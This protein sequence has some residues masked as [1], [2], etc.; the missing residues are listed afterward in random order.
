MATLRD[1]IDVLLQK[2]GEDET[3]LL[4]RAVELGLDQLYRAEIKSAYLRGD[5]GRQKA[6]EI[7]GADLVDD[8]DYA[9]EAVLA[10]AAWG[11][12]DG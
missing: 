10:D 5:L 12:K 4:G 1:K 11:L 7:L 9:Q 8:L 6:V 3:A 2:P